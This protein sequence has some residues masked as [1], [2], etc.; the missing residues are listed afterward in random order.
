MKNV[1][2]IGN[3]AREHALAEAFVRG[4]NVELFSYMK[5]KNP[6]IAGL[7][8]GFGLGGYQN[9]GP[10]EAFA[11]VCHSDIV[12]IGPENPLGDGIVDILQG[13]GFRCIGPTKNLARLETSKSWTRQ[14]FKKYRIN[15]NPRFEV[16]TKEN[17]SDAKKFLNSIGMCVVKPDGLTAGKGVQVQGDHFITKKEAL[18]YCNDVLKTHPA[19]VV[20]EK[21]EGE[22]FSL[23]CL[24]DGK[25]VLATP[26]VQDHKRAFEDDKGPNTGGMGTYSDSNHLLPFLSRE[27]VEEG[28]EMTKKAAQA[29]HKETGEYY[30]GVMYAGC[31]ATKDG[32][33]LVEYNARFGDPETMN[34]MPIME[35]NFYDVCEAIA[36]QE[37]HKI[38]LKFRNRATVCKYLVPK[39]YPDNPAKNE[40]VVIGKIPGG[41]RLYYASVD[42][43]EDGLYMSGSRAIACLGIAETLEEAEKIA[44]GAT[45]C[46]SGKVFHRNDIG[47]R[48]LIQKRIDNMKRIRH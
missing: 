23:Q 12:F 47:T 2:L 48:Q 45:K 27:D 24:T 26:P 21:F 7:S 15:G 36:N 44:E 30:K 16:F 35:T 37:L 31:I 39:G 9:T 41:A 43:K 10:I 1:L 33:K 11:R 20:E 38:K 6:G 42:Q 40:K 25:T 34:V 19:V 13:Y 4:G 17:I 8:Q 18:D 14:L 22:E 5:S 3:G 28:L 32:V 46:V 29:I